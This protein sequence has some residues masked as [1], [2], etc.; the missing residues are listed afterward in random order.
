MTKR[1]KNLKAGKSVTILDVSKRAGV[2]VGTVSRVLNSTGPVSTRA[3]Q[4]VNRAIEELEY[5]PDFAA[6]SLR[7]RSSKVIGLL[8]PDIAN[9]AFSTIA[10]AAEKML[11]EAGY[12]LMIAN[13]DALREREIEIL[14]LFRQR[15]VEGMLV[16]LVDEQDPEVMAAL[17]QLDVPVCALDRDLALAA[18]GVHYEHA[19]GMR[20]AVEYL[21]GLGHRRIALITGTNAIAPTRERIEGY[22]G[23]YEK[24]GI[25]VDERLIRSG[26]ISEKHG[27]VEASVLLSMPEPPTAY[28]AGANQILVGVLRSFR[29]RDIRFP[30]DVSLISCDDTPV[31]ELA[32]PPITVIKRDMMEWGATAT[33]LLL[34][35]LAARDGEARENR[36]LTLPCELVVR[37]SCAAI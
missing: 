15:R 12:L 1:K 25:P 34:S 22:R 33:E 19:K 24:V 35:R 14:K 2:S 3:V 29:G 21:F 36:H 26:S 5:I 6:Q 28:I 13:S 18:D 17:K 7:N 16:S 30:E 20:L 9:A 37:E 8:V 27:Y 23:A 32:N 11:R 31:S 10:N 4:A